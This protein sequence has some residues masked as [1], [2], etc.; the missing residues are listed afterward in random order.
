MLL[1][2]ISKYSHW[3]E[4]KSNSNET[5]RDSGLLPHFSAVP[6]KRDWLFCDNEEP[7]LGHKTARG[8]GGEGDVT[9]HLDSV[10]G[11]HMLKGEN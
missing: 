6:G 9:D 4:W 5:R 1:P 7:L 2:S 3:L 10:M 8:V 11:A